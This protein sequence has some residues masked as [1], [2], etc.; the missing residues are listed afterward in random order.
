MTNTY[1]TFENTTATIVSR[2]YHGDA[3]ALEFNVNGNFY[4]TIFELVM[5]YQNAETIGHAIRNLGAAGGYSHDFRQGMRQF[6]RI[7]TGR[8]HFHHIGCLDDYDIGKTAVGVVKTVEE[9]LEKTYGKRH[10][11]HCGF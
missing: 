10:V 11:Y 6:C 1:V 5:K 4:T 7:A 2:S 3:Q 9:H 8:H